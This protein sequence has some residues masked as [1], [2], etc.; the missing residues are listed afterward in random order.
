MRP[1]RTDRATA[2]EIAAMPALLTTRDVAR[3]TGW[4]YQHVAKLCKVG[5]LADCSV[6]VGRSYSINK[7]RALAVLGL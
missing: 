6:K 5:I 3:I 4:T 7:E 1:R 2:E